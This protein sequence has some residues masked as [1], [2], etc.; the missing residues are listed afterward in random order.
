[1]FWDLQ[2]ACCGFTPEQLETS[3][4]EQRQRPRETLTRVATDILLAVLAHLDILLPQTSPASPH[5]TSITTAD[6]YHPHLIAH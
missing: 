3:F 4:Q 5:L 6:S 2:R 1:L